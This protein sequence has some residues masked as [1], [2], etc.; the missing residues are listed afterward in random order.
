[1]DGQIPVWTL[2]DDATNGLATLFIRVY[3]D[4]RCQADPPILETVWSLVKHVGDFFF[5][6]IDLDEFPAKRFPCEAFRYL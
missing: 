2:F 4:K 5:F 1:M 3:E 6:P